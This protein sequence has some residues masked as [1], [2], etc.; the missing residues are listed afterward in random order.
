MRPCGNHCIPATHSARRDEFSHKE[1]RAFGGAAPVALLGGLILAET[2]ASIV[3]AHQ[4]GTVTPE[5][6][7]ARSY[8]RIRAHDDNAIFISLRAETDALAEARALGSAGPF[9]IT[10]LAPGGADA[11]PAKIGRV[12]HADTA[13]PLGALKQPQPPLSKLPGGA[14]S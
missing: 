3:A 6:T 4:A 2:V 1:R 12:F 14:A 8:D 11:R 7:V 9:G 13:L 10:L 5:Q